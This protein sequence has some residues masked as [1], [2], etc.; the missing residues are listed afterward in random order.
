M[1]HD[2]KIARDTWAFSDEELSSVIESLPRNTDFMLA[3][4]SRIFHERVSIQRIVTP[5]VDYTR[6][7]AN[8]RYGG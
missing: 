4:K 5:K 3:G 6:L 7:V 2:L 1:P 8:M